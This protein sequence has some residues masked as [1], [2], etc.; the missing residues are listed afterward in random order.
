MASVRTP[1]PTIE[2]PA[3]L[4]RLFARLAEQWREEMAVYSSVTKKA[5]HPAYQR[6]IGMGPAALPLIFR[7]LER[8]PDHW[9]WA[10]RAITGENPVRPEDAGNLGKMTGAWLAFAREHGYL[11]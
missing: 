7:E 4:E 11:L 3:E 10:L 6:I 1:Q 2:P 9:F 8:Q 5:L